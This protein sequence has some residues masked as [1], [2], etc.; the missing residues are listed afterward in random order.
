MRIVDE[1]KIKRVKYEA[2]KLIVEKGFH[3][4]SISEIAKRANVSDGYLYRHHKNK[5]EFVANI[6]ETQLKEFHDLIFTLLETKNTAREVTHGIITYLFQYVKKDQYSI[7]FAY[8]LIYEYDFEYPESR[9]IAIDKLSNEILELGYKTGEFSKL[10]REVD[11]QT[12]I[13]TI[14][15]KFIEFQSKG[16]Y[17]EKRDDQEEIALLVNICMNAL[18]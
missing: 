8:A 5:A 10:I 9:N 7:G 12:T 15:I 13:L 6:L 14:P 11:I 1:D 2:K 18:K 17:T 4:A 3:G 16:F